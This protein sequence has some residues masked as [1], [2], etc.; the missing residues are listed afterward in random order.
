MIF[1]KLFFKQRLLT[2]REIDEIHRPQEAYHCSDY[3]DQ[4]LVIVICFTYAC[5]SP[6]ILPAGALYFLGS[7]IVYKKQILLVFSPQRDNGGIMFPSVLRRMLIGLIFGQVT[8]IGYT[9][10]REAYY[11]P[12]ALFPLPIIT[13]LM[14]HS[15]S[16]IYDASSVQ[17]SLDKAKELDQNSMVKLQFRENFYRQS[18]LEESEA[19]PLPYRVGRR[20]VAEI[21]VPAFQNLGVFHDDGKIV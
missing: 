21:S 2:Q 14:M 20:G 3:A 18:V 9:I 8:L 7:L 6:I 16:Q 1:L 11:Q 10:M 5:I 15:F 4:L 12:L 19:E 17:L 13:T